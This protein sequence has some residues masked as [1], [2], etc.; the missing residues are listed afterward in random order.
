MKKTGKKRKK[1]G[2]KN[3]NGSTNKVLTPYS[4]GCRKKHVR[5]KVLFDFRSKESNFK[6]IIK[7]QR[8]MAREKGKTSLN[9]L[10]LLAI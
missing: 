9:Y 4:H 10:L 8:R 1:K 2:D 3:K 7:L 5:K 6:I